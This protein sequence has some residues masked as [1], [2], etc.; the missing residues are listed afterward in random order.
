MLEAVFWASVGLILYTHAGYPLLLWLLAHAQRTHTTG[1]HPAQD[2]PPRVSLIVAA[3]DE[4]QVIADKVANALGLDYPRERLELI[5]AS[6]GSDD[7]TAELARGAGAD[8]VLELPRAGKVRTQDAG[9]QRA[10]GEILVF[11]DANTQLDPQALRRLV[12]AFADA[13]VGYACGHVEFIQ[14]DGSNQEGAY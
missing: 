11:S 8:T 3:R 6:D 12:A 14:G 9:V 10:S 1:L 2:P 5:V 4:E 13:G 7:R